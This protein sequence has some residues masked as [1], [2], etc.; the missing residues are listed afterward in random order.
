[1]VKVCIL[2]ILSLPLSAFA[3]P[4]P[5]PDECSTQRITALTPRTLPELIRKLSTTKAVVRRGPTVAQP[6]FTARGRILK[7]D[8]QEIQVF[9]YKTAKWAASDAAKIGADGT[10]AETMV[11]WIAPP[12]F[13][14][15]N[16]LIVLYVGS[17]PGLIERLERVLGMQFAGR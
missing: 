2:L 7:I 6:F 8:G 1:M 3:A 5:D 10:P 16:K 15:S 4:S 9:E 12:H 14:K 13:Y 11:N 17:D